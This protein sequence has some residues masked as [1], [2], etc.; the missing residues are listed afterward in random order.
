MKSLASVGQ[1]LFS[2]NVCLTSLW[3]C[4]SINNMI[5]DTDIQ[6]KTLNPGLGVFNMKI[7]M[8]RIALF[9]SQNSAIDSANGYVFLI[10]EFNQNQYEME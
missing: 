4:G 7:I 9:Y 2:M 5:Y 3:I 6:L 10:K 8:R 1:G